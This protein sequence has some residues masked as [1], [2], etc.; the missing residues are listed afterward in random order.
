MTLKRDNF[1]FIDDFFARS[2]HTDA[3]ELL[4][5]CEA[6]PREIMTCGWKI[7]VK[8]RAP[9]PIKVKGKGLKL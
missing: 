7:Y 9:L 3:A 1:V 4:V 2:L 8:R 5:L 6:C